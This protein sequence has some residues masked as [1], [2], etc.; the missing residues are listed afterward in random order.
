MATPSCAEYRRIP[1]VDHA[2][3][4]DLPTYA[5]FLLIQGVLL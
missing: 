4:A 1:G 5:I 3:L 2:S